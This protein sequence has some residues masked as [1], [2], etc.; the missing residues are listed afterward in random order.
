MA[1]WRWSSASGGMI[2]YESQALRISVIV[3][4]LVLVRLWW[5]NVEMQTTVV[6]NLPLKPDGS[7]KSSECVTLLLMSGGT[8]THYGNVHQLLM[9]GVIWRHFEEVSLLLMICEREG[10]LESMLQLPMIGERGRQFGE[11]SLRQRICE[12]VRHHQYMPQ[13]LMIA[14]KVTSSEDISLLR[15]GVKERLPGSMPLLLKIGERVILGGGQRQKTG[16]T[17]QK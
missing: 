8:D 17:G 7:G 3:S 2:V 9:S 11:K 16:E 5:K 15:T 12:R 4:K 10:H 14:W 13:L 1:G 6:H